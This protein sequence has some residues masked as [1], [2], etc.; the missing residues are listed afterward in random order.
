MFDIYDNGIIHM[1][2]IKSDAIFIIF[3]WICCWIVVDMINIF[4][5][6]LIVKKILLYKKYRYAEIL[7]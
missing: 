5:N 7:S 1:E 3:F 6:Y 2:V 4:I